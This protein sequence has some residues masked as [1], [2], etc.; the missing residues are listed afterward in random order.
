MQRGPRELI[1]P[2]RT[3]AREVVF[4][5]TVRIRDDGRR[6]PN[7]LGDVT[8]GPRDGRFVYINAGT[9]AGDPAS[10]WT[11]RAKISLAGITWTHVENA[12]GGVL[13]TRFHGTA[14]DGGPSCATVPLLGWKVAR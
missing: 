7:V 9:S 6:T 12:R 1:E 10:P 3:S 8:Q 2:V 5:A 13:E 14:R 4:E 11:R